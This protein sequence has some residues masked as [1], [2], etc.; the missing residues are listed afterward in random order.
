MVQTAI[1]DIHNC[2]MHAKYLIVAYIVRFMQFV[3]SLFHV[4]HVS[5]C[6]FVMLFAT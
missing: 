6:K 3:Q 1:V 5:N 4:F 2:N